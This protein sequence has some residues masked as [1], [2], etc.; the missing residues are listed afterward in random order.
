MSNKKRGSKNSKSNNPN[1]RVRKGLKTVFLTGIVVTV[2]LI[3]TLYVL[4]GFFNFLDGFLSPLLT[5]MIG[6]H[7]P[8]LGL[9][10][11]ILIIFIMGLITTNVIG[12]RL[13]RWGEGKLLKIPIFKSIY[14]AVKQLFDAFS[15]E[16]KTAFK[17]VVLVEF[18]K[19]GSYSIGFLTTISTLKKE[20]GEEEQLY[21]VYIPTNH[22]YFGQFAL[23]KKN[24]IMFPDLTIEEGVRIII[25]GGMAYPPSIMKKKD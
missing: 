6:H 12:Q 25:S 24:E 23:F 7:I 10:S 8:G 4:W 9:L 3:I 19:K 13:F 5:R 14:L 11:A 20:D 1:I 16:N 15:P 21:S 22:I 2:P 17:Q 18:P